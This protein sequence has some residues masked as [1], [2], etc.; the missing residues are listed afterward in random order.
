MPA[1]PLYSSTTMAATFN[2]KSI[3]IYR[4]LPAQYA[5]F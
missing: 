3:N 5:V 2:S 1:I 4:I